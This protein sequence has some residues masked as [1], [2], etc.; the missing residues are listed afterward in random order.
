MGGEAPAVYQEGETSMKW[1]VTQSAIVLALGLWP[2]PA[3]A[4]GWSGD[5]QDIHFVSATLADPPSLQSEIN[6]G[7]L[8]PCQCDPKL[9]G[10]FAPSDRCFS[11]F[12]SPM[13][14]PVYF[15][16]PRTLTEARV[17]F[18]NHRVPLAAGSGN[19][20]LLAVQ[21]RAALTDRLSIIATKDG[22]IM[23]SNPLVGDGWAD[24]AAGLKYTL[25]ADPQEQKLLSAGFT[26]ELP[27]GS[28]D[29][30][31][32]NGGGRFDMFL[33]GAVELGAWH[34][35]GTT[36]LIL[37]TDPGAN[38]DIWFFSNHFDRR[39]GCSN[40][41]FVTEF[42]V[43]HWMTSGDG[44]IDGVEGGD[45]FNLGSTNVAGNTLV[46][47]GFGLK[48]KYGEMNELGLVWEVPLSSH[49]DVLDNRLTVDWII[50][51]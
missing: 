21:L 24:V 49:R 45:L 7:A 2:A 18:L 37:P 41:F 3:S 29:S 44:G 27:V 33:T 26:Y 8:C 47:G 38:T 6:G 30:L 15:E 20:D 50:R 34:Y 42:N 4:G 35:I 32:A 36:G 46:T 10:V 1:V 14:N 40:L 25:F 23:S 9:F 5:S 43:Y 22:Y 28:T 19:V 39:L 31:Q 11:G 48:Y 17:I 16:D 13:T 12:V 51:Y